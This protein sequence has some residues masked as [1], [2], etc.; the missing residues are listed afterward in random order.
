M[1]KR[2]KRKQNKERNGFCSTTYKES[3]I[4]ESHNKNR[5]SWTGIPLRQDNISALEKGSIHFFKNVL[6]DKV[7]S[8]STFVRSRAKQLTIV[9]V[10]PKEKQTQQY[11]LLRMENVSSTVQWDCCIWHLDKLKKEKH[12]HKKKRKRGRKFTNRAHKIWIRKF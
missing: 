12:C 10:S 11:T 3:I 5:L 6:I 8:W 7:Q 1:S 4:V 9:L 2:Q